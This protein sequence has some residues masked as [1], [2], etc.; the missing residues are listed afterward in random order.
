MTKSLVAALLIGVA[1]VC[2]GTTAPA[3][4]ISGKTRA[5]LQGHGSCRTDPSAVAEG[6]VVMTCL[7]HAGPF[8]LALG[9]H[10]S[11]QLPEQGLKQFASLSKSLPVTV[12]LKSVVLKISKRNQPA[13]LFDLGWGNATYPAVL[14]ADAEGIDVSDYRGEQMQAKITVAIMNNGN[15]PVIMMLYSFPLTQG[16]EGDE[17][18]IGF[19]P[20][21]PSNVEINPGNEESLVLDF[22]ETVAANGI[23][24]KGRY[25]R[26][27]R[28]AIQGYISQAGEQPVENVFTTTTPPWII[29]NKKQ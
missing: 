10:K 13:K 5:T 22:H 27:L 7:R 29:N 4:V 19:T 8:P 1:V 20:P 25:H 23:V 18:G 15:Q 24:V 2:G 14:P 9:S 17:T 16:Y 26:Y 3:E 21:E 28:V 6:L 11:S 12:T